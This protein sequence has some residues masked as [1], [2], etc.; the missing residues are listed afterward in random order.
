MSPR[1]NTVTWVAVDGA[2]LAR[3]E[4]PD[5]VCITFD[6][7]HPDIHNPVGILLSEE[8]LRGI[9]EYLIALADK[10]KKKLEPSHD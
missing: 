1:K 2:R 8:R 3:W 4:A 10:L 6:A 9:G 5:Q 7:T